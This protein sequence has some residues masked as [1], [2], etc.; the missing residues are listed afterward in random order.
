MNTEMYKATSTPIYDWVVQTKRKGTDKPLLSTTESLVLCTLIRRARTIRTNTFSITNEFLMDYVGIT[1]NTLTSILQKLRELK[2]ISYN[3]KKGKA[4]LLTL[5]TDMLE[6]MYHKWTSNHTEVKN[7]PTVTAQPI[8]TEKSHFSVTKEEPKVIENTPPPPAKRNSFV[9]KEAPAIA[10]LMKENFPTYT[11]RDFL[12]DKAWEFRQ[13]LQKKFGQD[14]G[15]TLFDAATRI[16][17]ENEEKN[18]NN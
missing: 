6:K 15:N 12:E 5:N 2:F 13:V 1:I 4:R 11:A 16:I 3:N 8:S 14:Y 18:D 17:K 9:P 7:E 10:K